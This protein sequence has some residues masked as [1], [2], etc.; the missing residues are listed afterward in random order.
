MTGMNRTKKTLY[1][2]HQPKKNVVVASHKKSKVIRSNKLAL[3]EITQSFKI[4]SEAQSKCHQKSIEEDRIFQ[5]N[6]SRPDP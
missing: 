2:S 3:S 4:Y 5:F 6:P 1:Q